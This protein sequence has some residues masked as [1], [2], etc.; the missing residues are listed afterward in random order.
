MWP[1]ARCRSTRSSSRGASV[2]RAG[3]PTISI[4]HT[5]CSRASGSSPASTTRSGAEDAVWRESLFVLLYDEHGGFYDHVKPPAAL[6][7]DATSGHAQFA[8]DRL[9][10]RVPALLVSPW[11][12]EGIADHTTYDHTSLPAT[13]KKMF[14]LPSFLTAR[15]AAAATFERNFLAQP[16][17]V[18]L[19]DLGARLRGASAVTRARREPLAAPALAAIAGR[20]RRGPSRWRRRRRH[21][22]PRFSESA[23]GAVS[24]RTV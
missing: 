14:G 23:A 17:T 8:F 24:Q 18:T 12:G 11:V 19:T 13:L 6:V 20:G 15:D 4:R 3:R 2:R 1:A 5:R 9:G 16:R 22:R 7:P 10:L 21:P